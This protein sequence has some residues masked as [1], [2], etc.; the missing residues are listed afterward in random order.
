MRAVT[1]IR[2]LF[3]LLFAPFDVVAVPWNFSAP[4]DVT[5]LH[6]QSIFHHLGSGGRNAIAVSPAGRVAVVW[7]DNRDGVVR[8]YLGQRS[9]SDTSFAELQ[10]SGDRSCYEPAVTA[11]DD[12]QFAVAWEE[13]GAIRVRVVTDTDVSVPL[14]LSRKTASQA[15]LTTTPNGGL[16]V[17]WSQREG[18]HTRIWVATLQREGPLAL[19]ITHSKA[20]GDDALKGDQAY[21]DILS[22]EQDRLLL[23]WEDRRKGHSVILASEGDIS[24]GFATPQQINESFWGGRALGY[25][26]GT[27]AM[28]VS[29]A[30]ADGKQAVAVWADKRDFRSGY[31]V[32]AAMREKHTTA[33]GANEKVQDGFA[34]MVAQWHPEIAAGLLGTQ[35]LTVSVW[36]DD[37]EGTPDIWLS[38]RT[39]NQW[40]DDL[41]VPGASGPGVQV[42]PAIALDNDGGLHLAWVEKDQVGGPSRVR[43]LSGKPESADDPSAGP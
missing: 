43:Y 7:E 18:G 17:A 15:A 24:L 40:S 10:I 6:G 38:W 35:H 21:P 32:Y 12:R 36:D 31:D 19:R 25:G 33:F 4:L 2:A 14:S 42:E 34:D 22:L 26:R 28:R 11:I 29:L 13:D 8:C 41:E 23:A 16:A 30:S 39:S 9:G 20:V 5:Q 37:R 27:G 1:A 3:F